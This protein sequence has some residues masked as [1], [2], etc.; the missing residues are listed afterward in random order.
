MKKFWDIILGITLTL[1]IIVINAISNVRIA[2]SLP[3]VVIGIILIIYHFIKE[4]IK[5]SK[6]ISKAYKIIK[7]LLCIG[8]ISFIGIEVAIISY[9]K[10]NEKKADYI[11]VLGAGLANRVIPSII[12]EGRLDA[13][14]KYIEKNDTAYIVLS[15]GQGEDEDLPESNAMSKYLQDRG[16]NKD[17]IITEDKSRDT[18]QNLKFSK[19]KIEEHSHKSIDEINVNIITT[20]F[21]AFRSSILAKKNGYTNFENYSSPTMWYMIPVTYTREAFAVVKSVIFDK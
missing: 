20:D 16:V 15:G 5:K 14:I 12:L 19:E 2:F 6:I 1:Y 17:R 8:L 3:I 11:I 9:P 10:Y 18:N 4:R 21:H 7:I 13:A